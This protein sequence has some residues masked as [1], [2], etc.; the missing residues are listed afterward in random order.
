MAR[1]SESCPLGLIARCEALV[2]LCVPVVAA[3][4]KT[5]T[6]TT[7]QSQLKPLTPDNSGLVEVWRGL[8]ELFERVTNTYPTKARIP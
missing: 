6:A 3:T 7:K 4:I 5:T 8:F 1:E 2:Q